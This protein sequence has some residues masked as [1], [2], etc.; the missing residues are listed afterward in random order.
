L[1]FTYRPHKFRPFPQKEGL[2][3]HLRLID[4]LKHGK[5]PHI[6]ILDRD[7]SPASRRP[8][9]WLN[10]PALVYPIVLALLGALFFFGLI[11]ISVAR[12]TGTYLA[13]I[14]VPRLLVIVSG[15]LIV[16]TLYRIIRRI[17]R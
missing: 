4:R 13:D 11:G 17:S 9:F 10:H 6:R 7:R 16:T 12:E 1:I 15:F 8:T 14:W 2:I 3:I 5:P